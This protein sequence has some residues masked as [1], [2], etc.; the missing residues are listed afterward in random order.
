MKIRIAFLLIMFT[1]LAFSA[2]CG[3]SGKYKVVAFA[4]TLTYQGQPFGEEVLITFTPEEGRASS[5]VADKS[6]KF[7]ADYTENLA[8]VQVGKLKVTIAP[9]GSSSGFQSPQTI[10]S[11]NASSGSK[12][13]FA[14]YAFGGDGFDITVD[15][16]SSDYKLDLP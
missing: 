1:F 9:Y 7:K 12:E 14:K 2:G 10:A 11:A 16:K 3:N 6:G 15:E 4:G 5:A 13:A 8:G